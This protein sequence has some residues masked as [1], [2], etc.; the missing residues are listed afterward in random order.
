MKLFQYPQEVWDPATCEKK[1]K[2]LAHDGLGTPY[3]FKGYIGSSASRPSAYGA[4]IYNGGCIHG[5]EWY[6]GENRPL[7]K[8]AKGFKIVSVVSW[9]W[10]IVKE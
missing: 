6:N 7:P 8:V 4:E 2:Y 10:R 3:P 1:A 9:G 5:N